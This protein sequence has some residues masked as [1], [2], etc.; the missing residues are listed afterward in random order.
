MAIQPNGI[1]SYK[2]VS[3]P[4]NKQSFKDY[5]EES[6]FPLL[7]E[8]IKA[9]IMDNVAFHKS[10]DIIELFKT[11][12]LEPIFIPPYTPRCNPIEEV[13]SIMKRA[14]RVSKKIDFNSKMEE[15]IEQIKQ[16]KDI[17]KHYDHTRHYVEEWLK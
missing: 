12:G 4:F 3:K 14:F 2:A 1:I 17:S 11:R 10:K 13:F 8:S 16:Y 6:L 5:L 9:I 15:V 7:N